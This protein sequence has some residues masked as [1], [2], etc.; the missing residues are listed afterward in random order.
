MAKSSEF[1]SKSCSVAVSSVPELLSAVAKYNKATRYSFLTTVRNTYKKQLWRNGEPLLD[2]YKFKKHTL[3]K[4]EV[5]ELRNYK[6]ACI[7]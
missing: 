7:R 2:D 3:H 4:H 6:E 5:A 1:D